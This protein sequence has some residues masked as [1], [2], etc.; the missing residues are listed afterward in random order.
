MSASADANGR[1]SAVVFDLVGVLLDWNPR[2]L[3][4]K[5]F[6]DEAE[7][8]RFL[9][10]VCTMQWH[11]AHDLGVPPEQTVPPLVD[12]HPE[13]AEQIWAWPRRSEEMVGG[14]IEESV[15]ILQELKRRDV[16]VEAKIFADEGHGY[17]KLRNIMDQARTM[18]YFFERY[19][20]TG[21]GSGDK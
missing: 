7:M 8:D 19:I 3:Y 9:S 16:P 14:P 6:D 12:A 10:E 21:K 15:Q 17:S 1:P 13:Y 2:Y 11:H 5:L 20:K 18:V 4:R